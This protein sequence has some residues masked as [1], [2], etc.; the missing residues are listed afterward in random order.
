MGWKSRLIP[1]VLGQGVPERRTGTV[2]FPRVPVPQLSTVPWEDE[3]PSPRR[4]CWDGS[5]HQTKSNKRELG[6]VPSG[7]GLDRPS[8]GVLPE[9]TGPNGVTPAPSDTGGPLLPN[10]LTRAS[11]R[12]ERRTRGRGSGGS[13]SGGKGPSG[14]SRPHSGEGVWSQGP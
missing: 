14:G 9:T 5:R 13:R 8:V 1:S 4:L 12:D 11:P 3:G 2:L 10:S 7:V 6:V